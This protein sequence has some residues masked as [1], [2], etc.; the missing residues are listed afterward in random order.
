M[1]FTKR[2]ITISGDKASMDKQIVLYRGDRE[3]EVQF[4][5]VYETIKYRKTNAI[6][7]VNA[8]FGQLVIQNDSVAIP[9]VTDVSPTS[10]GVVIFKF[11]KEMIDEITELGTYDFQIRLFDD[12]QTSRIT[13]PT[14]EDSIIIKEP[15]SMYEGDTAEVGVALAGV[16]KAQEEEYLEPFDEAGNYNET[17]WKTGDTITSGKLN[18]LEEGITGVNQ[19]VENI[20]VPTK[21]SELTNDSG[22]TTKKYV[23]DKTEMIP[24]KNTHYIM[25]DCVPVSRQN[26]NIAEI[27]AEGYIFNDEQITTPDDLILGN[28]E[29]K[30][31]AIA[32]HSTGLL[33]AV[34]SYNDGT[35]DI[36]K[37]AE[38]TISDDEAGFFYTEYFESDVFAIAFG[39]DY[40]INKF[41]TYVCYWPED[42]EVPTFYEVKNVTISYNYHTNLIHDKYIADINYSKINNIPYQLNYLV[43]GKM[44]AL[45]TREYV[46]LFD[47]SFIWDANKINDR[48]DSTSGVKQNIYYNHNIQI[49]QKDGEGIGFGQYIPSSTMNEYKLFVS[50][51]KDVIVKVY[52]RKRKILISELSDFINQEYKEVSISDPFFDSDGIFI[53]FTVKDS[54]KNFYG[55]TYISDLILCKPNKFLTKQEVNEKVDKSQLSFNSNGELVVTIDGI[56]K[57]F[58]PKTE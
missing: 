16:A 9:T 41:G 26:I 27:E 43:D 19:K 4:E 8:S 44:K 47:N 5:I 3:V 37:E 38:L 13:I 11:T 33:N 17:T 24:I 22:F 42:M 31:S 10:E 48:L 46:K 49:K 51:G 50:A 54:T 30:F 23:D 45:S 34:I 55:N 40:S 20:T 36:T 28:F 12:T 52:N 14:I 2:K 32:F 58:V 35:N 18:K 39:F 57:T 56:S 6:E 21:T 53:A 1:I 7:D 25:R 29:D 15:L